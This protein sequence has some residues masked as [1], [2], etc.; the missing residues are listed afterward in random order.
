[1][2]LDGPPR[3]IFISTLSLNRDP[4]QAQMPRC[5]LLQLW[6]D[7]LRTLNTEWEVNWAPTIHGTD[8]W[9]WLRFP[10]VHDDQ[11]NMIMKIMAHLE[12]KFKSPVC[13]SFAMKTGSVILSLACHKHVDGVMKLGRVDIPGVQH[14]LMPQHG[15]QIEIENAFELTI[16]GL[17]DNIDSIKTI[18]KR[19]LAD[20]FIVDGESTLAGV[21]SS[22]DASE[23]LI[24]HMTT[25]EAA[26][27][28]LSALVATTFMIKTRQLPGS[29]CV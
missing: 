2:V 11:E 18:L 21:R 19:W 8:K 27:K 15:H 7:A 12:K 10:E 6:C 14:P 4:S 13:S 3:A 17:T 23:A 5:D 28:V 24:F 29:Q 1:M 20:T 9:M 22:S 25:W 16:M 26:T